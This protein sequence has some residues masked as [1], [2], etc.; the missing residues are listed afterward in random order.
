MSNEL[1]GKTGIAATTEADIKKPNAEQPSKLSRRDALRA[2]L[3]G[4]SAA[5]LSP[6]LGAELASAQDRAS[7]SKKGQLAGKTAFI[8]G[9]AR[10]IGLAIAEEMAKEGANIAIFDIA[11]G[12]ITDVGYPI[13]TAADLQ[14]AKVKIEALGVKCLEIKGDVRNLPAL[15]KAM[16]QTVAD[17]GSLDIVVANAGISQAG[18]IEQFSDQ[19]ISMV[20]DINVSGVIKTTQAAA[21]IM[22]KQNSGRII[23]IS[24]ALGRMGNELFPIYTASKWA[25]IGFAK[26]AAL[27][28]GKNNILCNVVAPGLVRT[29]LADNDY[30]LKAMMPNDPNPSFDRF[31]KANTGG[32]P[33]GIGHLEP[34]DVAKAVLFFAGDATAK[35]TGEV[36]DISYGSLARSI[37]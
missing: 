4:A 1:N 7:E 17:L 24:S 31:S 21:P 25:V 9:G 13:S 33:I 14:T 8:T 28:Y 23:Y 3:V 27:T 15:K 26:S 20:F 32:S 30:V 6:F 12:T 19:E 22:K 37:A 18:T 16:E 11:S 5:A 2:G 36:F 29:K 10:G 34:I 35:V